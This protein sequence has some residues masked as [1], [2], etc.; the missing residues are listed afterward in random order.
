MRA[1][2]VGPQTVLFQVAQMIADLAMSLSSVSVITNALHL[3][4]AK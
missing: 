3:R 2:T 4:G 1:E